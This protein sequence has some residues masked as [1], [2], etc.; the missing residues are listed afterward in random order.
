[1]DPPSQ[2]PGTL[3][4]VATDGLIGINS[5][6]APSAAWRS[7]HDRSIQAVRMLIPHHSLP[8][9]PPTAAVTPPSRG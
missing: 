6:V 5:G 2:L 7:L 9:L 8:S 4:P 1:M 3:D